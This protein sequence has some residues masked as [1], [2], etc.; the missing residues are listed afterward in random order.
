MLETVERQS[1]GTEMIT[2]LQYMKLIYDSS[3][4]ANRH[5]ENLMDINS[6]ELDHSPGEQAHQERLGGLLTW[7]RRWK[8]V[9]FRQKWTSTSPPS[10]PVPHSALLFLLHSG[11]RGQDRQVS[12]SPA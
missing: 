7:F 8:R 5:R 11:Y 9:R 2:V 1:T 4:L 12:P 10:W 6:L 3:V